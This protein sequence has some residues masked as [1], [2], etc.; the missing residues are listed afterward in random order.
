[1]LGRKKENAKKREEKDDDVGENGKFAEESSKTQTQ[2][3][4]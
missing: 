4:L 2:G 3:T 1:M